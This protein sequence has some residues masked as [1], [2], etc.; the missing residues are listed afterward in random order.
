[1]RYILAFY[2]TDHGLEMVLRYVQRTRESCP[3][4]EASWI[5][6]DWKKP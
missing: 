4:C 5:K 2:L 6:Q 1:M 3:H